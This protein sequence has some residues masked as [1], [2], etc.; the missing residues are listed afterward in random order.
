[1]D[2]KRQRHVETI[3]HGALERPPDERERYV[4]EKCG[5]DADL[6]ESVLA[7]LEHHA[8][9]ELM[10]APEPDESGDAGHLDRVGPYRIIR[11][12]GQGGMGT[13]YLAQQDSP[14][15]RQA[16]LKVIRPG[17]DS[18]QVLARF[19]AERQALELLDHPSIAKVLDAG[20]TGDG[21][22]YFVM[23]Y[24]PGIPITRYCDEK[25]MS[26][27]ER[28]ALF[29]QVCH[30]IQH[31]HQKGIIHRD[32]KPGN[33]IVTEHDGVAVPKV[34]DFGVAKAT[35][36]GTMP[37]LKFTGAGQLIGTLEYMSPEQADTRDVDTR[38][39]VYALGLL[40]YELL[41]GVLPFDAAA[42]G[43]RGVEAMIRVIRDSEPPRPSERVSTLG[44]TS[45][46][47]ARRRRTEPR[48]L[49]R[50]IRGD[51]DWVVMK[52]LEK[53]R[54]RRYASA[55]GLA[56]DLS[57]YLAD[58]PVEA[59]PP[60]ALYRMQKFA[61][62]HRIGVAT[63]AVVLASLVAVALI[64]A[65]QSARVARER[66]RVEH[67]GQVSRE[68]ADYLGN[69]FHKA[70]TSQGFPGSVRLVEAMSMGVDDLDGADITPEARIRVLR[71]LGN[72][73]SSMTRLDEARPVAEKLV[74]LSVAHY[75]GDHIETAQS[76]FLLVKLLRQEGRAEEALG[77]A[78]QVLPVFERELGVEDAQ[79]LRCVWYLAGIN[80]ELGRGDAAVAYYE[81]LRDTYRQTLGGD[82]PRLGMLLSEMASA[83][84]NM[85]RYEDGL[86]AGRE[87]VDILQ[88][89]YGADSP[90]VLLPLEVC[91]A[92]YAEVEQYDEALAILDRTERIVRDT[93]GA[94]HPEARHMRGERGWILLHTGRLDSARVAFEEALDV[95]GNVPD[96]HLA[97]PLLG[98]GITQRKLRNIAGSR[99]ALERS[100]DI[101]VVT[102]G[103]PNAMLAQAMS[104]L[105]ETE[106]DA[107]NTARADSLLH[108]AVAMAREVLPSGHATIASS[109]LALGEFLVV[110]R[111]FGEAEPLLT[112]ALD[113]LR[114]TYA[115]NSPRVQR[116]KRSIVDLYDS[117]GSPE[118]AKRYLDDE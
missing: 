3:F 85:G 28:I 22:P 1:M 78:E 72:A 63:S 49:A 97:D 93:Y 84:G 83:L 104:A 110:E 82:H 9:A 34:I 58:K 103:A 23:E 109:E 59:R 46:D 4:D 53:N 21:R 29:L 26:F 55:A 7:L 81:R 13:V 88:A 57:R 111:R 8:S 11:V 38:S 86:R 71:V 27:R 20:S 14:I 62:R 41:V 87:A 15:S 66:D 115:P 30:A 47:I 99:E 31:A 61:R 75:G 40:L 37:V 33:V 106:L 76:R 67:E 118:R 44:D 116:A 52:A 79:T 25:Q 89:K 2:D 105:G 42:L 77:L 98:L 91:S 39:D 73:Y 80:R 19:Q 45:V 69:M 10:F 74:D 64:T 24:V 112:G 101:L 18:A 17:M 100:I 96:R 95:P 108:A 54:E 51:V 107:G 117:W 65:V 5:A 12:L 90:M 16:A 35:G 113:S 94:A 43:D 50:A 102:P 70:A 92:L 68:V 56:S 114:K 48:S 32:V 36:A 60:S 6:R